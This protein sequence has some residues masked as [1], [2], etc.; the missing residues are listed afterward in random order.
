MHCHVSPPDD[1]TDVSRDLEETLKLAR[2]EKLDFVVLTPHVW[3]RFFMDQGLRRAVTDGQAR[4]RADIA[5]LAP[6]DVVFIQGFEYTDHRYGHVG[7]SFADIDTVLAEVPLEDAQTHPAHFFEKWVAHGGMLVV[8]HPFVT[9]LDSFIRIARADLSW[10]PFTAQGPFPAEVE[11]IDRIAQGFEVYNVSATDLRDR[12]LVGESDHTLKETFA[13]LDQ[14]IPVGHRRM[15]PVG[16]S[17]S[18]GHHLQ[19]TTFVLSEARTPSAIHDAIVAGR[20]CVRDGGACSFEA[21]SAGTDEWTP[22]GGVIEKSGAIEVRAHGESI[23]I[24]VNGKVVASPASDTVARVDLS[25]DQCSV[26]R[27]RVGSGYSGPI[28]VHCG[29][30]T[31]PI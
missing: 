19:A 21:R 5:K 30:T 2:S 23:D 7:A 3:S 12:F 4:L 25:G 20:V 6:P 15:T 13:A 11:A 14:R 24:I 26:V 28:Y 18:H 22:I 1:A 27:A 16:G 9:P 8:N 17:D 10:R 29:V 31:R